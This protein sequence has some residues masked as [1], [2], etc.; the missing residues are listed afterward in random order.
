MKFILLK[1]T[2]ADIQAQ[3]ALIKRAFNGVKNCKAEFDITKELV[4]SKQASMYQVIGKGVSV[5]F[6]GFVTDDNDYLILALT[7][8]GL[9]NVAPYIIDAVKSQG[10]R[11]IKYHT[12]RTGMTAILQSFGFV[13]TETTEHDTVMSLYLEGS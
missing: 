6:V 5:R 4:L 11:A 13:Q 8:K 12:V 7:G 3:F 2:R 10:Y 1:P 9:V